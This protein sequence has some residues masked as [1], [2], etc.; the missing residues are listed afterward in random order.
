VIGTEWAS[1]P[2]CHP[3][4][5]AAMFG[6]ISSPAI[7]QARVAQHLTDADNESVRDAVLISVVAVALI[8]WLGALVSIIRFQRTYK[9]WLQPLIDRGEVPSFSGGPSSVVLRRLY[10]SQPEPGEGAELL[11]RKTR[12][13]CTRVVLFG[14]SFAICLGVLWLVLALTR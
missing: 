7:A 11:R 2:E 3:R 5:W 13:S 1:V 10:G 9:P 6:S 14:L 12:L 4:R 8:S